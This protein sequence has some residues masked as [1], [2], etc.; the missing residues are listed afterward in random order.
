MLDQV[1]IDTRQPPFDLLDQ[2]AQERLRRA[3]DL[4]YFARGAPIL[5]AESPADAAY[6]IAKGHV[7]AF[8]PR[9]AG[10]ERAFADLGPGD[11]F[12]SHAVLSGRARHSYRAAED[13]LC[14]TIPAAVF[15][16]LADTQS[17]FGAW[18]REG[19]AVKRRHRASGE[20]PE[21]GRLLL[22]R[23]GEA[24]PAPLVRIAADTPIASATRTLR[25]AGVDCLVV[26]AP[27]EGPG[28]V[29]RTDLLDALALKGQRPE[30]P[31][32][33]LARRPLIAI[34]EQAL[35][36]Q[37]LVLMTERHVERVVVRRG[38]ELTGTLGMAE[39]LANYSAS[40]HLIVLE[41]GRAATVAEVAGA[42]RR[43]PELIG[44]LHAQGA[45]MRFLMELVT[46]LNGRILKRLYELTVPEALRGR[47]C[48][49]VLGSEG[50]GEQL[51]RTD[52]DNALVLA[53]DVSDDEVA[54]VAQALSEAIEACG[55]PPCPGGVMVRHP[56]W[57][58]RAG[59]WSERIGCWLRE[60]T[61]EAM[62]HLAILVDAR[63]V[64]GAEALAAPVLD[65]LARSLGH[66]VAL[67]AM[68]DQA[69]RFHTP[70]S[71]FGRITGGESGTDLKK[72][73]IF[74]IVHGLRTLALAAGIG[75]RNTF[76]RAEAL[77]QAGVLS[78]AFVRDLQ[79]AL[80][81]LLRLRLG[82]QLAARERGEEPD[83]R[84]VV[85]TLRRLDRELLRDAL[86]VVNQFQDLVRHRFRLDR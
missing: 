86:R 63:P 8:D 50:R 2:A 54:P 23:A 74:P 56:D 42:A 36:Y 79:Q 29:T 53:E 64:A 27:E 77:A 68:A 72:G 60:P 65:G 58:G 73:A 46:A 40:S 13:T 5:A 55:W 75:E 24:R 43:L 11:L 4:V 66:D 85:S 81:V 51:L 10:G 30:D 37:A 1:D 17:R 59:D 57:R 9:G 82:E 34:D 22:T 84:I 3:V 31:V 35:L 26:D 25:A 83:N 69:V 7:E 32:G 49:L 15:R 61:P 20:A 52:Q 62:M 67:R 45:K 33:P 14:Y 28:I 12:G 70:L 41:I 48:L 71:W 39:V 6:V 47:L 38:E 44:P 76:R 16:E 19:M 78:E 18:F 21:A 80:A